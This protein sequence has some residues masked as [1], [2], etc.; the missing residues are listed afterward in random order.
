MGKHLYRR[1]RSA[2]ILPLILLNS[3]IQSRHE[4]FKIGLVLL[5]DVQYALTKGSLE[6]E[7][8]ETERVEYYFEDGWTAISEIDNLMAEFVLNGLIGL[9]EGKL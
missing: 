8:V 5:I 4:G 1:A 2:S 7:M 6:V 3:F 9:A